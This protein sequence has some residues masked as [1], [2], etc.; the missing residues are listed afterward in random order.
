MSLCTAE[1]SG[2]SRVMLPSTSSIQL[3]I[4]AKELYRGLTAS[5]TGHSKSAYQGVICIVASLGTDPLTKASL[6]ASLVTGH[7]AFSFFFFFL[8]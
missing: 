3:L 1:Q 2:E 4:L 8:N 7:L 5:A 6:I